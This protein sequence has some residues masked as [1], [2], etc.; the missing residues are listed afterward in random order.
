[1]SQQH[2]TPTKR[3]RREAAR[4]QRI[5]R[6][7][8]VA[9]GE[10]RRKRLTVLGGLLAAA[11]VIVVAAV[12]ISSGGG[13]KSSGSAGGALQG[14]AASKALMAGI[15]Q[16]GITLGK[17]S[18]PVTIVEFAD[19]QCPFCREYTLNEMPALI[20]KYV[21]TG[22]AKMELRYMTFLGSDSLKAARVLEATGQKDQLWTA[23]DILYRNQGQ[24]ETGWVTDDF[25]T[26][27]IT[28]VGLDPAATLKAAGS[29]AVSQALAEVNTLTSRYGVNS[30][31]TILVGPTGGTLKKD[32]SESQPTAAGVGQLVDAALAG[33]GGA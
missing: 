28:A 27:L 23:S 21:R 16:S 30:T 9:A 2:P 4:A 18:A 15:P 13:K 33:K 5:E 12:L 1:M 11:V 31:P 29:P 17:A 3:E 32:A 25:L 22:K 24:E 14:V 6:E 8:A 19:P 26:K 10:A 7:Q 20:Q